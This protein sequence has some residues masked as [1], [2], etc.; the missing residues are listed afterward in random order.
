MSKEVIQTSDINIKVG[1]NE[2]KMPVRIDWEA[3]D[4][5]AGGQVAKA[6]LLSL[7][8]EDSKDTLKIDLWTTEMQVI[9]MDR[10]FF[11]TL[12]GLAD[13]YFKAT[14][15]AELA[16]SMRQFVHYFGEKTGIL[17]G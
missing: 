10:F 12:R 2:E 13:T 4:N 7:F 6:M 11:Q 17:K 9:E 15:N 14:Q 8:D 1:L 3:S 16:T 5:P